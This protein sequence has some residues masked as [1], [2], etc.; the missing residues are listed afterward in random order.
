MS[1]YYDIE[2][3]VNK[4]YIDGSYKYLVKWVG[5]PSSQN[6]W[7]PLEHF[8]DCM[9]FIDKFEQKNNSLN[10]NDTEQEKTLKEILNKKKHTSTSITKSTTIDKAKSSSTNEDKNTYI[11]RIKQ[12]ANSLEQ[13]AILRHSIKP[14][15]TSSL[16]ETISTKIN[17]NSR[18]VSSSGQ[19]NETNK[20]PA[21]F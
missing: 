21:Q 2:Q 18:N 5:Y 15:P 1:D 8:H 19:P 20:S 13:H 16:A 17:N 10:A 11:E 9:E 12:K 3:I 4:K 14:E 6:T 7:E